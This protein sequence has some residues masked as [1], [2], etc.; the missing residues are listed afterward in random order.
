VIPSGFLRRLADAQGR[1][2]W[3]G[4]IRDHRKVTIGDGLFLAHEGRVVKQQLPLGNFR[5]HGIFHTFSVAFLI[6]CL[7]FSFMRSNLDLGRSLE[8]HSMNLRHSRRASNSS[9]LIF[10][11]GFMVGF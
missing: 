8:K 6:A 5:H 10:S 11:V 4:F 1:F 3:F 7:A 9:V 2:V